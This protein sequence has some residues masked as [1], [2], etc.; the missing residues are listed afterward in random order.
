MDRLILITVLCRF[1]RG[2]VSALIEAASFRF[3]YLGGEAWQPKQ[4]ADA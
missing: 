1:L 3:H 2:M 4:K